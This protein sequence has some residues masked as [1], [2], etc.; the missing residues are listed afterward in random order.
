MTMDVDRLIELLGVSETS[1]EFHGILLELGEPTQLV[2]IGD[3]RSYR[4]LSDGLTLMCDGDSPGKFVS[5]TLEFHTVAVDRGLVQPYSGRL[6]FAIQ[7]S[8]KR[9]QIE[10]KLPK[11]PSRVAKET[12]DESVWTW[13]GLETIS[14]IIVYDNRQNLIQMVISLR[15]ME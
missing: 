13:I 15:K 12:I 6:P 2:D 3:H 1:R 5:M 10:S 9:E 14:L 8:D 4:F 7:S 11:K